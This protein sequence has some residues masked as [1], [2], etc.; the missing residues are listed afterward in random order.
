M[1]HHSLNYISFY[2]SRHRQNLFSFYSHRTT[3]LAESNVTD[4]GYYIGSRCKRSNDCG[5]L[6]TTIPAL[7]IETEENHARLPVA[8][9]S[10]NV[11]T[12]YMRI[13]DSC[14]YN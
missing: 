10:P 5:L 13:G 7:V 11:C 1:Y 9:S 12:R 8:V 3:A 2:Q 6:S 14:S 4:I